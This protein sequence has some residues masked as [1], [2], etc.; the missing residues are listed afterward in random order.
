MSALV[1]YIYILYIY[2]IIITSLSRNRHA[3]SHTQYILQMWGFDK[4]TSTLPSLSP[5]ANVSHLPPS[6]NTFRTFSLLYW[7]SSTCHIQTWVGLSHPWSSSSFISDPY[8]P[9]RNIETHRLSPSKVQELPWHA[10]ALDFA[11]EYLQWH[12][13]SPIHTKVRFCKHM[14]I[15]CPLVPNW[16]YVVT[17]RERMKNCQIIARPEM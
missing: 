1:V 15:L 11:S 17:V 8:L 10:I 9:H 16:N 7:D 2:I 14:S 6:P 5:A 4:P 12:H 3:L 13:S